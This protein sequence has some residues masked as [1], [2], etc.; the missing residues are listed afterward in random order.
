VEI[1]F[2]NKRDTFGSIKAGTLF[3]LGDRLDTVFI[4]GWDP[5]APVGDRRNY[6][7]DMRTGTL[8]VPPADNPV[9]IIHNYSFVV[10]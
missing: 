5:V 6:A 3:I 9:S 2:E 1:T 4:K 7:L 10:H 8:K